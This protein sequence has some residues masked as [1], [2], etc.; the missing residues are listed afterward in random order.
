MQLQ[1]GQPTP[2]TDQN[3]VVVYDEKLAW[4]AGALATAGGRVGR[5]ISD[6]TPVATSIDGLADYSHTLP[7]VD[8]VRQSRPCGSPRAPYDNNCTADAL[9]WPTQDFGYVLITTDSGPPPPDGTGS[10]IAG[11]Y[12]V[13]ATGNATVSLSGGVQGKML[14]STYDAATNT[15]TAYA[16]CT[17]Q[18]GNFWLSFTDTMRDP[19]GDGEVRGLTNVRVLQPGYGLDRA[20]DFTD[21]FLALVTRFDSL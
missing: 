21:A 3:I 2:R 13:V 4:R 14:N 18:G 12:M 15:L 8:V 1:D 17:S 19:S 5:R 7:F 16:E 9:G 10:V 20:D 11:V 6:P